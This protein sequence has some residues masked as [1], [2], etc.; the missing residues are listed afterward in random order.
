MTRIRPLTIF[1][2]TGII[3]GSCVTFLN[4]DDKYARPDWLARKVY[5]QL[6][7]QP[8]LSIF[9]QCVA[10][11][12]YDSIIN[13]SGSYT[14]FAPNNQAFELF[15]QEHPEYQSVED[16]PI[17]ELLKIVKYHIVQNPWSK[18]QLRSLDVWGWIDSADLNNN[19]P[20]GFKRETLLLN[21]DQFYGVDYTNR[22]QLIIVDT[23]QSD[24]HRRVATDSRK[25]VPFFYKEYFDIY[26][27]I[28]AG[29]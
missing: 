4:E 26:N 13:I 25:F 5:T 18:E 27:L 22:G 10:R 19:K 8:D 9:T 24:W 11:T 14:V 16:M 17:E 2:F 15:F 21:K 29:L 23:L 20:K 6:L 28:L 7:A 1:L 12:G 3:L